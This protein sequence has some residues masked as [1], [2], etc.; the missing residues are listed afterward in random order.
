MLMGL[1][2]SVHFGVYFEK[3]CEEVLRKY[4]LSNN[5]K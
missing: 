2:E 3:V 5:E 4:L 1:E